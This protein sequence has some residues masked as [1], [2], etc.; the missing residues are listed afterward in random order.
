MEEPSG[1]VRFDD[2]ELDRANRR[3]NRR[4]RPVELGSRYFDALALLTARRGALVTKNEFMAEVWRGVPVTDEALTQCVRSLRRTLGDDA[5][6]PRFIETV[7][8]HGYRFIA[9][10]TSEANPTEKPALSRLAGSCT[11]A[12]LVAGSL[13][14]LIYGMIAGIGGGGQILILSAMIGLLGLLA[15]A[16]IGAGLAS[17]IAWRGVVDGWVIAGTSLGGLSIGAIGNLLSLEG[18]G[19][20]SGVS[21]IKA[22]GPLEGVILGAAA[23]IAAQAA[24]TGRSRRVVAVASVLAGAGAA[25][26]IVLADGTL[27]AGSLHALERGIPGMQLRVGNIGAILGERGLTRTAE[28][29][30]VTLECL[31]FVLA[32]AIG[33]LIARNRPPTRRNDA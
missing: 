9:D 4:G 19:L 11:V 8:K 29:M 10:L 1:I 7:P 5:A 33:L 31:T 24:L 3:L 18:V 22:T 23:G 27:L 17:T 2:F 32:V 14:G 12:G 28:V 13:A 30:T 21:A 20:L 15:G 16:G 26:L 6:N 25:A